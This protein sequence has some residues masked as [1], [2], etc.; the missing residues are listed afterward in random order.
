MSANY[1]LFK[2]IMSV[3]IFA[4]IQE[5]KELRFSPVEIGTSFSLILCKMKLF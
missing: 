3:V 1:R 5:Q 4:K 2:Q